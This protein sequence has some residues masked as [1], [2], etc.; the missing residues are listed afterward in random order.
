MA[1]PNKRRGTEW[2]TAVVR[3][4]REHVPGHDIRRVAQTGVKDVG[5]I[6]AWPFVLECKNERTF[7]P[8]AWVQQATEEAEHAGAPYGVAVAKQR[9]KGPGHG[10]VIMSLATFTRIL[11]E[12]RGDTPPPTQLPHG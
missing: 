12:I 4:L 7:R 11:G 3:Y 10:Y 9:G 1:N 8:A 5:D 2:E 6:H